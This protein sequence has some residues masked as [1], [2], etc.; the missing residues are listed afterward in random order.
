MISYRRSDNSAKH[1]LLAFTLILLIVFLTF[2]IFI[3]LVS[4]IYK[5]FK[6]YGL[7][8][9]VSALISISL[10]LCILCIVIFYFEI[11]KKSDLKRSLLAE[12]QNDFSRKVYD[13]LEIKLLT[14]F[15]ELLILFESISGIEKSDPSFDQSLDQYLNYAIATL[16]KPEEKSEQTQDSVGKR[17]NLIEQIKKYKAENLTKNPNLYLPDFERQLFESITEYLDKG[18]TQMVKE[19]LSQLSGAVKTVH[20]DVAKN[21]EITKW[22]NRFTIF[23]LVIAVLPGISQAWA[24]LSHFFN[25]AK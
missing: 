8:D 21:T 1:V 20:E 12:K 22:N 5:I 17:R 3:L 23:G 15:D 6:A 25:L 16:Y 11:L 4:F 13:S 19:K 18:N 24:W 10:G 2:G 9:D 7:P 14:D